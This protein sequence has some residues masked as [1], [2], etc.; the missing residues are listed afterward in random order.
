VA[1]PFDW[2]VDVPL[3]M[4]AREYERRVNNP[5]LF[6]VWF[7]VDGKVLPSDKTLRELHVDPATQEIEIVHGFRQPA[8]DYLSLM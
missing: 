6:R 2:D 1:L 4:L 5:D 8:F 3:E 7:K